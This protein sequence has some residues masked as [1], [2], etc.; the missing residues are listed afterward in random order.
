MARWLTTK[1][2]A[3]LLGVTQK[4]V[5]QYCIRGLLRYLPR[6][7]D[8]QQYRIDPESVDEWLKTYRNPNRQ[9]QGTYNKPWSGNG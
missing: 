8:T 9:R 5:Q 1:E 6:E 3:S 7:V 2:V 4:T